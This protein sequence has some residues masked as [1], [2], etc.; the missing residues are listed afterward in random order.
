MSERTLGARIDRFRDSGAALTVYFRRLVTP[1]LPGDGLLLVGFLEGVI[2]WGG[3]WAFINY[4]VLA[5]VG[6]VLS[7][8]AL[9]AVLTAGIVFIGVAYTAPTVRRNRVWMVWGVLN[10]GATLVNVVAVAGVLPPSLAVYGYWHPWF[11]AIGLGYLATAFDNWESP[12]L[13]KQERIVYA[14]GGAATLLLLAVSVLGV[15][16]LVLANVFLVGGAIQLVPIG[17]D[18]VADAVLVARRQ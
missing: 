7:V 3:S 18:V 4:P 11:L 10:L 16:S 5:P 17:H 15:T 9:W 12:Q 6:P 1:P 14:L 8:V 13:R 2:G